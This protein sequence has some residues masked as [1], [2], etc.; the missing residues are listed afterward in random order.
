MA[1]S[2]NKQNKKRLGRGLDALLNASATLVAADNDTANTSTTTV[3]AE[4]LHVDVNAISAN[5][6]QPRQDFNEERLASLATSIKESGMMQPIVLRKSPAMKGYELVAGERR[7]RA[8]QIAGLKTVPA[9]LREVDA[10][11]AAVLA[12]VENLQREDLSA[13]E[14]AYALEKLI[15]E[16]S[17]T[18][19]QIATYTGQSR[20]AVTNLLRLLDL[21]PVLQQWLRE[22]KIQMAHCRALLTVPAEEQE[23]LAL[24]IIQEGWSVHDTEEWMKSK[25]GTRAKDKKDNSPNPTQVSADLKK[26]ERDI[27]D[28]L[29]AEVVV[30]QFASGKGNIVVHYHSPQSLEGVLERMGVKH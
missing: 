25:R 15:D 20:S 17:L 19:E 12:L 2:F 9:L 3:G 22:K 26:L 8:A 6:W 30:K 5:P 10:K 11:D 27:A 23:R 21:T 24:R 16:F 29:G 7:W 13:L 4:L 1:G 28:K 14:Q 18:H